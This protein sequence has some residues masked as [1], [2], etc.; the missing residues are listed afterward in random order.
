SQPGLRA[1]QQE[2]YKQTI[3]QQ[4]QQQQHLQLQQQ[5]HQHQQQ[6][7][8][9]RRQHSV[10]F[11][12]EFLSG[13][14]GSM[15]T[16][17]HVSLSVGSQSAPIPSLASLSEMMRD[18]PAGSAGLQ[19]GGI[20]MDATTTTLTETGTLLSMSL[21]AS[22]HGFSFL[23]GPPPPMIPAHHLHPYLP[24]SPPLTS[25]DSSTPTTPKSRSRA[26]SKSR[27]R[28]NSAS[29]I[30]SVRNA[31]A[32]YSPA[33][34][35]TTSS[36]PAGVSTTSRSP[37]LVPLSPIPPFKHGSATDLEHA[38]G[39]PTPAYETGLI[40][41]PTT[42]GAI[43]AA[44]TANTG[45]AQPAPV[46]GGAAGNGTVSAPTSSSGGKAKRVSRTKVPTKAR[47][48]SS[49]IT[50]P[51]S[52]LNTPSEAMM[53][54]P[55]SLVLS[56]QDE[57]TLQGLADQ[58]DI[59]TKVTTTNGDDIDPFQLDA[60]VQSH[61]QQQQQ[62]QQMDPSVFDMSIEDMEGEEDIDGYEGEGGDYGEELSNITGAG[63]GG[64]SST[65]SSS[66]SPAPGKPIPCPIPS[67]QKSF[68]R[69]F[70]LNAHVKSHDTAKP[71]GCH[72][73]SRVFSRK[74]DL[75]R[76]IRVH[77]GSKPYVC[78]NCQKA[79][80]RTD[81]LCRHY[82]VEETCRV[83]VEQ[84]DMRK[85]AQQQVQQ[86]LHQEQIAL[87]QAQEAHAQ[88]QAQA[89]ADVQVQV[90]MLMHQEDQQAGGVVGLDGSDKLTVMPMSVA[91]EQVQQHH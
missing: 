91:M 46:S 62:Y 49:T 48:R 61:H 32:P 53:T 36:T 5:Q 12:T 89:Q 3:L 65:S 78:V 47:S 57:K 80:A 10:H 40:V 50:S 4:Q 51:S 41:V 59:K 42:S 43:A 24:I 15:R 14:L 33:I 77:T 7:S 69:P 34:A 73:C 20:N 56:E 82:K 55:F 66:S 11:P 79:F 35:N 63:A 52:S 68:T 8:L 22:T 23:D 29:S 87:Q 67:C 2:Q 58:V 44:V 45:S 39:P 18:S 84:D 28:P 74:H 90:Q 6:Q 19:N 16:N 88:A 13:D 81:A 71:Y 60:A 21:P 38:G 86:Q 9:R 54:S 30:V 72:V 85:Q 83:F 27:S 17:R 70:N 25:T 31:S 76:H 64:M 37:S 1:L 75:Q 26:G